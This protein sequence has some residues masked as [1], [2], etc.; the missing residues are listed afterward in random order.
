MTFTF[1]DALAIAK[2]HADKLIAEGRAEK[3]ERELS[4]C[5]VVLA[6]AA[7]LLRPDYPQT[8]SEIRQYIEQA[9]E[10]TGIAS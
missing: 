8:A 1:E 10:T 6:D 2:P 5:M 3:M 7:A 9:R 4:R